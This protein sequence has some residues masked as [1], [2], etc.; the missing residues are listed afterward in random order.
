MRAPR[1]VLSFVTALGLAGPALSEEPLPSVAKLVDANKAVIVDVRSEREWSSGHLAKAV[2]IPVDRI[3]SGKAD[4][5]ALPK[6]K[7]VYLH[8]AVGG[9]ARTAASVLKEKGYDARPL[10]AGPAELVKAGFAPA[11]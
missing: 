7:P 3:R 5:S 9:R 2:W 1:F 6:D 4:L 10:D 8:C 11:K